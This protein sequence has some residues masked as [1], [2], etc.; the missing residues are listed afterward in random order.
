MLVG[1]Q[2][3]LLAGLRLASAFSCGSSISD[4]ESW[5]YSVFHFRNQSSAFFLYL[6]KSVKASFLRTKFGNLWNYNTI[7]IYSMLSL[8]TQSLALS[9]T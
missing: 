7:I 1:F 4:R 8:L 3:H 6:K 9:W 2:R 5:G